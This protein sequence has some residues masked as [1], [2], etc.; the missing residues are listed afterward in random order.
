MMFKSIALTKVL[1]ES[2][3]AGASLLQRRIED[4]ENRSTLLLI[5]KI[6]C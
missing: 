3:K 1:P 4:S 2:K 6:E 5:L